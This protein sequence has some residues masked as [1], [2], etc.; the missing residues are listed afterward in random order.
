[1]KV[2][3]AMQASA[4]KGEVEAMVSLAEVGLGDGEATC[5][6]RSFSTASVHLS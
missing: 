6:V 3:R 2:V 1:M 5:R 4:H